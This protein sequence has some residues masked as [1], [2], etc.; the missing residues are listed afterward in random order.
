MVITQSRRHLKE[1]PRDRRAA[2]EGVRRDNSRFQRR[3]GG[4]N[5]IPSSST[6]FDFILHV[7]YNVDTA[8]LIP[9]QTTFAE[10]AT[11]RDKAI[12]EGGR[13]CRPRTLLTSLFIPVHCIVLDK[14]DFFH[15]FV[16][17][18]LMYHIH[19]SGSLSLGRELNFIFQQR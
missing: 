9:E 5:S 6:I 2:N 3:D 15:Q 8:F 18:H 1:A 16:L 14:E 10:P 12:I 4:G 17:K 11:S 19:I 7:S 13:S